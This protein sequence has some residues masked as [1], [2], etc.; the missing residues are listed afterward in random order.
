MSR[1]E[2]AALFENGRYR[3]EC[4]V[5]QPIEG[6]EDDHTDKQVEFY[7]ALT[8]ALGTYFRNVGGT[9]LIF[10]NVTKDA[11]PGGTSKLG[12]IGFSLNHARFDVV[13][14]DDVSRLRQYL[15]DFLY[16]VLRDWHSVEP[17]HQVTSITVARQRGGKDEFNTVPKAAN[18]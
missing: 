3:I 15:I 6:P 13:G 4:E 17:D 5:A 8:H 7:A 2:E 12:G 14:N 11:A 18:A 1:H 10:L 16:P 9:P